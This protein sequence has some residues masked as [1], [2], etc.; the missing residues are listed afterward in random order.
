[1]SQRRL[2]T[3]QGLPVLAVTPEATTGAEQLVQSGPL[4]RKA[5]VDAFL[6]IAAVHGMEYVLTWNC[7]HIAN[8]RMRG[9]RLKPFA[10]IWGMSRRLCVRPRN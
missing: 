7:K 3:V 4:P 1:M 6:G 5:E 2:K 8:A 10:G 9:V